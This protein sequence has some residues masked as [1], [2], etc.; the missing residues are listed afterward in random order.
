MGR[1]ELVTLFAGAGG[2]DLAASE[3]GVPAVGIE[4]D[5]HACATRRAAGLVTEEG[6]VREFNPS[7]FPSANVLA[8][9]PPCQTFAIAS[10][11][12]GRRDLADVLH[13]IQRMKL[14]EDVTAPLAQ[15][16]D[17]RTGLVLEPLRWALAAVDSG[18][19][20]E[21]VVLVQVPTVLPVWRAIGEVLSA[22]GYSV[23]AD[24]LKAEEFGVPQ[25]RRRAVLIARRHGMAAL[26]TA[27]HQPYR[28][29]VSA[30]PSD[31][32]LPPCVTMGEA[33]D[34]PE[35]F[36]IVANYG[37]GGDPKARG[38]RTSAEP[39]FTVTGKIRRSQ[40]LAGDGS[41]L[42]RLT[43]A[44]AGQ[45]QSFPADYP[46]AGQDQAQQIGNATPPL[47][48]THILTAALL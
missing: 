23:V 44:E 28:N 24:V 27:T 22:E 3:L 11:A 4:W 37:A 2:L 31:P 21:A 33:L 9:G 42:E 6:D 10:T 39:A 46:W 32:P 7:D 14:R 8:G 40:V 5:T 30:A 1:Y 35:P 47:L 29:R 16:N 36:H 17:E 19:P 38:R 18:Y 45:L 12:T 41:E 43:F 13:F 25:T 34:R 26:P 15:L 48:A 20:Y